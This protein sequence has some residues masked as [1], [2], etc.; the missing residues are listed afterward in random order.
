MVAKG[1]LDVKVAVPCDEGRKPIAGLGLFHEKAGIVEDA[2]GNR[3]AFSGSI[4]ETE[5]GWKY[6]WDS[7]HCFTTWGARGST[8]TA[9]VQAEEDSFQRPWANK[10]AT[11]IVMDVPA[12]VRLELLKFLPKDDLPGRLRRTSGAKRLPVEPPPLVPRTPGSEPHL[13]PRRLVW[14]LARWWR[15]GRRGDQCRDPPDPDPGLPAQTDCRRLRRRGD[16]LLRAR[17]R[18][19]DPGR[20]LAGDQSRGDQK[21]LPRGPWQAPGMPA[22]VRVTT[23]PDY[24]EQHPDSIELWSPGS[25]LFPMPEAVAPAEEIAGLSWPSLVSSGTRG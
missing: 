10:T 17:R 12:E 2:E 21:A 1:H 16:P 19:A 18:G 8:G 11:A 20:G 25:P 14:G 7:F 15:A 9:H 24:Y 13:D 23:D 22:P 6:N 5:F 3:L 4:N